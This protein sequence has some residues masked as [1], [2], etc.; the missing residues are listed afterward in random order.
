MNQYSG[1]IPY[2]LTD[3]EAAS[4]IEKWSPTS[5]ELNSYILG[6]RSFPPW[7]IVMRPSEWNIGDILVWRDQRERLHIVDIT[8]MPIA[9]A[10]EEAKYV[11]P[12]RAYMAELWRS[13]KEI[14]I[15]RT[16][17]FEKTLAVVA[18]VAMAIIVG[19]LIRD[20]ART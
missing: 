3:A 13:V 20:I 10:I 19:P 17:Q 4:F 9:S 15:D 18:L 16:K 2:H 11:S 12:T 14:S 7:G 6:L 1:E 5:E 8:A